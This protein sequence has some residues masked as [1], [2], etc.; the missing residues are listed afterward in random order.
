MER[1]GGFFC[2][3]IAIFLCTFTDI[4]YVYA[5]GKTWGVFSQETQGFH[6][7]FTED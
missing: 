1:F 3:K 7:K 6:T 2:R 5:Y 4:L